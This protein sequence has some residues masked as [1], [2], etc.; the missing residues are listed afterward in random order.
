MRWKVVHWYILTYWKLNEFI[1]FNDATLFSGTQRWL[2]SFKR[3][4]LK[5]KKVFLHWHLAIV[6]LKDLEHGLKYYSVPAIR[7][8]VSCFNGKKK[9]KDSKQLAPQSSWI[10]GSLSG[11]NIRNSTFI[12]SKYYFCSCLP[13]KR[14]VIYEPEDFLMKDLVLQYNFWEKPLKVYGKIS[15]ISIKSEVISIPL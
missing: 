15:K 5:H 9:K 11:W 4:H 13:T 2:F 14:A 6:I 12:F 8:D 10:L 1:M 3:F 7:S